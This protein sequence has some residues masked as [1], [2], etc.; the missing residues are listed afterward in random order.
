MADDTD[1][2]L[3]P[4]G[5]TINWLNSRW[6]VQGLNFGDLGIKQHG[7]SLICNFLNK[8]LLCNLHSF[9]G[10]GSNEIGQQTK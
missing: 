3:G 10:L 2:F 9:S 6:K 7:E 5:V 8:A 4:K 1:L